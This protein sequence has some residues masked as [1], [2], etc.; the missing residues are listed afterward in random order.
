MAGAPPNSVAAGLTRAGVSKALRIQLGRLRHSTNS[1]AERTHPHVE[2]S[3][4]KGGVSEYVMRRDEA[5]NGR[6]WALSMTPHGAILRRVK[7]PL[8]LTPWRLCM[9]RA[10]H[11]EPQAPPRLVNPK[12]ALVGSAVT[13]PIAAATAAALGHAIVDALVLWSFAVAGAFTFAFRQPRNST[14]GRG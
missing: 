4:P 11:R 7:I 5:R 1:P 13:L 12:A 6:R 2:P 14:T 8:P 9:E 3:S 10:P